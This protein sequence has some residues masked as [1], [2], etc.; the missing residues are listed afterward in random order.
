MFLTHT[1]TH[2]LKIVFNTHTHTQIKN[3]F[4]FN[5]FA[6]CFFASSCI[7]N[8][9]FFVS[10]CNSNPQHHHENINIVNTKTNI[11]CGSFCIPGTVVSL[12]IRHGVIY[13]LWMEPTRV[14]FKYSNDL[15]VCFS[16]EGKCIFESHNQ[17][18]YNRPSL[19]LASIKLRSTKWKIENWLVNGPRPEG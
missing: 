8:L 17:E 15:A 7:E 11:G 5:Y 4:F 3:C 6:G 14:L 9:I 12:E 10:N 1:H 13:I 2:K 16:S 19:R 18:P